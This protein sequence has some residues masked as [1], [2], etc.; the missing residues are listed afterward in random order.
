[1][2]IEKIEELVSQLTLEEKVGMVHGCA[3][4][5]TKGIERL[6]IPAMRFSDG[7][8]GVRLE[9]QKEEWRAEGLSYDYTSYLPSNTALAAT[10]N[11]EL[12][13]ETGRILGS[14]TRGRG[15]DMILAPGINVARSPL[16]GRNFEYM[17]EDPYLISEMVVPLVKGIEENDVSSCVKH[18]TL[19]NQETRRIDVN[20]EASERALREIYLP[21][22]EAAVKKGNAKSIMGAYNKYF[23]THC[24]HNKYLLKDILRD[25]WG[26]KGITVS[27]WGGVHDTKEALENGMDIEM[28]VTNNFD[29]YYMANPL[30][31]GIEQG[32][33]DEAYLDEKVRHIL[34]VMNELHML[35]GERKPGAY[36][37]LADKDSL[38]RTAEES[39]ILLKNEDDLLPLNPKNMKKLVVL[40]ENANRVHATGGGSAEIK[41]L[42]EI[43]PL[44]GLHM[45]L[46]G[47]TEIIYKPAYYNDSIANIWAGDTDESGQANS[48]ETGADQ[49]RLEEMKNPDRLPA[50]IRQK[51][52]LTEYKKLNAKLRAE[53]IEAAKNAD[54]VIFI[55]GLTHDFDTEGIDRENLKLPYEQE[56]I[57]QEL[58]EIRQDAVIVLHGGSPVEM[59]SFCKDAKAIVWDWYA[60]MEGGYALAEVLFGKVNPSGKL[61]VTFPIDEKHTNV[62]ELGEFPGTDTVHYTDDIFVGYR[63]Y[64]SY[65]VPVLFP[66]GHGLSY[67]AFSMADM[68]VNILTKSGTCEDTSAGT[69]TCKVSNIGD[70]AG[71]EIVQVYVSDKFPKVTKPEKELKGFAKV[72]L[73]PGETKEITIE[74]DDRAFAYYDEQQRAFVVNPGTYTVML[75]KSARDIVQLVDVVIA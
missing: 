44:M 25:E 62:S 68:K 26:F 71:A 11:R 6:G 40:G 17:G 33:Y 51:M 35:D 8:M 56:Q 47:N 16:C 50:G 60:G 32:Q 19:N 14:E 58:L 27:D 73:Q 4:F 29:S 63:Y 28:A 52:T 15:K 18:Y 5:E 67:T 30:K 13:Y 20:V 55:G 12:A 74:L 54:A 7:P 72:F 39:V 46:G 10:W 24:C 23:D 22:F 59:T 36:N 64:D 38:R 3:L 43:T 45:V 31:E 41:A 2:T 34:Y 9:Y 75:A 49:K 42:Y 66:F 69:V 1:M 57:I 48:V 61:P 65:Q 70:R 21:G 37:V 53:A